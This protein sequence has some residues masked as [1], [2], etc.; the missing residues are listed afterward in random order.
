MDRFERVHVGGMGGVHLVDVGGSEVAGAFVLT[1]G[2][3]VFHPK[4]LHF[5]AADRSGHPTVLVAMI[6][7]AAELA[8]LP[9][10]GHALE[11]VVLEN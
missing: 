9:A 11:Q 1:G 3:V 7:D 4:V 2:V 5:E 8:D 10:D 6:M